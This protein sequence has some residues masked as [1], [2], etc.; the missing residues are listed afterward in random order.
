[1]DMSPGNQALM[2]KAEA[3]MLQALVLLDEAHA[4]LPAVHLQSA[5]DLMDNLQQ[6]FAGQHVRQEAMSSR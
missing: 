1:M 6:D 5:L 4:S 3:L 2:L